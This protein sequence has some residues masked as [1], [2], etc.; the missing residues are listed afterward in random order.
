MG[1]D[2]YRMQGI[3]VS[4]TDRGGQVTYHG[5]GQLVAYP[6][7]ELRGPR[8]DDVHD[9]VRRMEGAMIAA[10]GDFGVEAR[11]IEGLTGVWV[12]DRAAARRRRAQD[13][14]DRHPREPRG[15]HPWARR[16]RRQRPA[17]VRVGGALRDRGLPDDLARPASSAPSRRSS[18]FATALVARLGEA[19]ERE[20][21]ETPA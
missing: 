6:I 11:V 17:A 8:P 1:E 19:Y 15:H 20:P 12:G 18:E 7:V 4:E 3:E 16:Q 13:R 9:F 10:L 14:L 21:V 2:W 5:P